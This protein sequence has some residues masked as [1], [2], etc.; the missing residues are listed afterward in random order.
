MIL[1]AE[2]GIKAQVI[3]SDDDQSS[4]AVYAGVS[5]SLILPHIGKGSNGKNSDQTRHGRLTLHSQK[6]P[7]MH[8]IYL[9]FSV[10]HA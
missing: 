7:M 9:H 2:D 5:Q 1:R 6:T 3:S 8:A 4:L 10:V